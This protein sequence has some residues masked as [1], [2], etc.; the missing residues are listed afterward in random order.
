MGQLKSKVGGIDQIVGIKTR[1]QVIKNRMGPPL[2]SV[3]FDI[4]FDRGIL[5][6]LLSLLL[7]NF[8]MAKD[9]DALLD[10][11]PEVREQMYKQ[12][13]DAYILGYKEAE[14]NANIDSTEFDD[15]IE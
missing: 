1:A 4:Y 5:V 7:H 3:D 13:C 12:I 15:G 9:F 8:I 14:S 6:F 10:E 11:R 2:R